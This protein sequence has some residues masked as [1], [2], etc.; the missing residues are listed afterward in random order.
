MTEMVYDV[1]KMKAD[2]IREI[3]RRINEEWLIDKLPIINCTYYNAETDT[4]ENPLSPDPLNKPIE[5]YTSGYLDV[6]LSP[7]QIL[8]LSCDEVS[9]VV[10]S[11][12]FREIESFPYED[13]DFEGLYEIINYLELYKSTYRVDRI[14]SIFT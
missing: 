1:D 14:D 13:I 7:I 11:E 9:G 6:V 5:A 4:W 10:E 3:K 12:E 2:L 8:E